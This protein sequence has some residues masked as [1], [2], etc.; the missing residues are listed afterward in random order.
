MQKITPKEKQRNLMYPDLL[1]Q[2][3]PK[4]E[5]ILLAKKIPWERFDKEFSNRYKPVGRPAKSTRL[6]VGLLILKQLYNLSDKNVIESWVQ[7][8]YFQA[9]CGESIFQ[10]QFPCVSSELTHFRNRIGKEGVEKI[11][12]VSIALH[13]KAARDKEV[14]VDTT[15]QEKNITFPTD[16]KLLKKVIQRCRRIAHEEDITLRRSYSREIP[17]LFKAQR[18]KRHPK[19][20]KKAQKAVRRIRT[21]A[22][23]LLREIKR[24]LP[25]EALEKYQEELSVL[26]KVHSQKRTDKNKIYSV[27]EPDVYCI[28]KGKDHKK[29]EFGAKA[30]LAMTRTGVLVAATNFEKNTFDGHTLPSVLSQIKE[31]TGRSPE[32]AIC[33][34]GFR[35]K[36]KVGDTQIVIPKSPGKKSTA[37]Q[38]HKARK[39]FRKRAGIEPVIGHIKSD[40]RMARNYLKGCAGDAINLLMAAAA[41]NFKKLLRQL[42]IFFF[43]F[44]YVQSK[45]FGDLIRLFLFQRTYKIS[46]NMNS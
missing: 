21:I 18:F 17:K 29:Y 15:V 20:R 45:S 4:H 32:T 34:R 39:R 27:H 12:E 26:E 24:K 38:K 37:Y 40:F 6:M 43:P 41:F 16:M 2:L 25:R 19:N 14:L 44:V 30:A 35:G 33:D 46:Q 8:P 11:F 13:G 42:H 7:N 9:F 1:E 36:N 31:M 3:N 23:I 5:L 22:G 10:W 28:S